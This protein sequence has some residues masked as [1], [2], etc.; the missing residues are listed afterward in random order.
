MN[1]EHH[2]LG[3]DYSKLQTLNVW[4]NFVKE[5]ATR[6]SQ[7][8][9]LSYFNLVEQIVVDPMHNLILSQVSSPPLICLC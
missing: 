5:Y 6:Y 4:K 9:Q 7:L 1:K 8:S 2:Q 3:E